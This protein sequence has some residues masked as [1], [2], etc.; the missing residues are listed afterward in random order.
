MAG[1]RLPNLV[2]AG[3][4]KAGTTSLYTYLQQHPDICAGR[5]KS[6]KYFLPLRYGRHGTL[7]ALDAYYRDFAH[8]R[9]ERYVMEATPWYCHGG[10]RVVEAVQRT[11]DDPRI[12]ISVREPV[13]RMWSG[14]KMAKSKRSVP[15]E[16]TFGHYVRASGDDADIALAPFRQRAKASLQLGRYSDYLGDW[17]EAFGSRLRIVFFDDLVGNPAVLLA[18]LCRWLGLDSETLA[19][20]D[21]TVRNRTVHHRNLRLRRL[22]AA[23]NRILPLAVRR[24]PRLQAAVR[25][26]YGMVNTEEM[27]EERDPS[28]CRYLGEYYGPSN[29]WLADTLRRQ[30]YERLPSWLVACSGTT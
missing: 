7:G 10:E 25:R 21:F 15:P 29:A 18:D 2:I 1:E 3:V 13:E 8:C 17:I 4:A 22:A 5:G 28:T 20:F 26:V 19:S 24:Q 9:D 12:I 11:L 14:Y 30:G 6:S 27:M 16:A 23:G